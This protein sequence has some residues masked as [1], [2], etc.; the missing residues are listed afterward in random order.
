MSDEISVAKPKTLA[1]RTLRFL[2]IAS[3]SCLAVYFI[4]RATWRFSGSNQWELVQDGNGAKVY[5]LK[6]PGSDLQQIKGV[7]RVH[8]SL[9]GIVAWLQDPE[10]CKDAG[11]YE[12]KGVERVDD[13][14]RYDYFRF[15]MPGPFKTR[16]FVLR[17]RFHQI[18]RTKEIW[19]EFAAAPEKVPLNA[20]CFRVTNMSNTWRLTPLG[21]G[22]VEA[23]YIMNMDWGGFFP[24][25]LSN[26]IRPQYLFMQLQGLQGYL[27]REKFQTATF[28]FIQED[29][30]VSTAR[31]S[32]NIPGIAAAGA[33]TT[34]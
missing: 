11:C 1:K 6:E 7:V 33:P 22:E 24:D 32:A 26:T 3:V 20:C 21:N 31:E 4:A 5:A 27:N 29:T 28:D 23:E 19:A 34:P 2:A 17:A 30:S 12:A 14:L 8:S 25:V 18:P 15:D 16:D 10:T 13:Q 9:A